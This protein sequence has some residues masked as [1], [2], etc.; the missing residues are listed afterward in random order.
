MYCP[1]YFPFWCL[2]DVTPLLFLLLSSMSV[3]SLEPDLQAKIKDSNS[4]LER[5]YFNKGL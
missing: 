2:F 1:S 3:S 4:D 5:V